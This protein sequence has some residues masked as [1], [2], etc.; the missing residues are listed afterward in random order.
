MRCVH[1]GKE[2]KD[3]VIFCI[4]CDMPVKHEYSHY[5]CEYYDSFSI[6]DKFPS[7]F[8]G[9]SIEKKN[10][11][12]N[13]SSKK[14]ITNNQSLKNTIKKKGNSIKELY[15]NYTM[16][17]SQ[18]DQNQKVNLNIDETET[19]S[20]SYNQNTYNSNQDEQ[21]T[22][23]EQNSEGFYSS[24]EANQKKSFKTIAIAIAIISLLLSVISSNINS[25]CTPEYYSDEYETTT[26]YDFPENPCIDNYFDE[27]INNSTLG[28]EE[29]IVQYLTMLYEDIDY[30]YFYDEH[31]YTLEEFQPYISEIEQIEIDYE[32]DSDYMA[33]DELIYIKNLWQKLILPTYEN[34]GNYEQLEID[35][36]LNEFS[37]ELDDICNYYLNDSYNSEF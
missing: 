16:E 1:C 22:Y 11:T 7:I 25:E 34:N 21:T 18:Q 27:Y 15:D 30:M 8:S 26:Y 17:N 20:D 4:H 31:L 33:Y 23:N 10:H 14:I 29:L 35:D 13:I 3:N 19:Y 12:Q 5:A 6:C 2:V 24:S 28:S 9:F 37:F 32:N 36:D